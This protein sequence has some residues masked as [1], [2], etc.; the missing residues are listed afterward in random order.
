MSEGYRIEVLQDV[1]GLSFVPE[2]DL[3]ALAKH[4]DL[5]TYTNTF[6]CQEGG[7]PERV[8]VLAEGQAEVIKDAGDGRKF[9]VAT[10]MPGVMFGHVGVLTGQRRTAS[11][12]AVG[13]VKVLEIPALRARELIQ[14]DNFKVSSAFRRSLI[15]ALARQVFSA[16]ATTMKLAHDAGLTVPATKG[17]ARAPAVVG[18]PEPEIESAL[19]KARSGNL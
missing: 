10:L 5:K 7:T 9:K 4:F 15:V 1:P 14:G 3:A 2:A 13:E 6:M 18:P 11:V 19:L 17:E 16:T 12:R 8:F